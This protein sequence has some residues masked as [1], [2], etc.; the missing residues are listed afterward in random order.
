MGGRQSIGDLP[1]DAKHFLQ[2][3]RPRPVDPLLQR[4]AGNVLHHKVR[5]R[6]LDDGVYLDDIVVPDGRRRTRFAQEALACRRRGRHV[7]SQDFHRDDPLQFFI[8]R[9][10]D[11]TEAASAEYFEDVVM[12]DPTERAGLRRR[13]K[14]PE[15][16]LIPHLAVGFVRP[17]SQV[18]IGRIVLSM[19][20]G[21]LRCRRDSLHGWAFEK[22][23]GPV[24]C[25]QQLFHAVTTCGIVPASLGEIGGPLGQI[26]F[27][28]CRCED[29]GIVHG[30]SHFPSRYTQCEMTRPIGSII[31][32]V[33]FS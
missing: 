32:R 10:I 11:D 22:T 30:K 25:N 8:E 18:R 16:V 2:I 27:F 21:R 14:N 3:Q 20:L 26:G 9:A 24:V 6:V 12:A 7:R 29:G 4:F 15:R 19:R 33:F 17:G 5:Q 31:V 28:E 1:T 23:A 13:L